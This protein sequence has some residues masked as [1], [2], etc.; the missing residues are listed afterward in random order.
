MLALT[1]M[2]LTIP[3]GSFSIWF[4]THGVVLAPWISW[5]DTHFNFSRVQLVP[6]II[7]RSDPWFRTSVELTRW[8]FVISAFVF[9][10]LFGFAEEAQ[11]RYEFVLW[12][13]L[14]PL[15]FQSPA[16]VKSTIVSLPRFVILCLIIDNSMLIISRSWRHQM[17]NKTPT[18]SESRGG[19]P[20]TLCLPI[21]S[22]PSCLSLMSSRDA[23]TT[24]RADSDIEKFPTLP[25]PV[26]SLP[27]EYTY[28]P[29]ALKSTATLTLLP[30]EPAASTIST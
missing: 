29:P 1:D 23:S 20:E 15:G 3:L 11:K 24:V 21:S 12:A 27:S 6:A 14:R 8:L 22:K 5:E 16:S 17:R 19:Y 13:L 18:A 28:S 4:A 26:I 2:M 10:I 30:L 7:W 25:S 9:F